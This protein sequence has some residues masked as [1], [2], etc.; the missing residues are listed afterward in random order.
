MI[1]SKDTDAYAQSGPAASQ[2]DGHL[3]IKRE[4]DMVDCSKLVLSDMTEC[5][6][7]IKTR[8]TV[9]YPRMKTL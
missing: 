6:G 5:G 2:N 1:D 8:A 7:N 3:L 4:G 9:A